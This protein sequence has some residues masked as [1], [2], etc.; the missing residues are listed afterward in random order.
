MLAQRDP[1]LHVATH[2]IGAAS[3]DVLRHLAE[4]FGLDQARTGSRA[5]WRQ[6]V[7]RPSGPVVVS[8]GL[9]PVGVKLIHSAV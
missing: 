5:W 2:P 1:V 3:R 8:A 9:D 6:M 4:D 7:P